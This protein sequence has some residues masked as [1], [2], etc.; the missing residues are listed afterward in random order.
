MAKRLV[1]DAIGICFTQVPKARIKNS[2]N[3]PATKVE[4]RVRPPDLILDL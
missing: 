1:R 4:R 2:K 3:T